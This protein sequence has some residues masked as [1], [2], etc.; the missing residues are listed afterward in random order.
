MTPS[1]DIFRL[2]RG[3]ARGRDADFLRFH[4]LYYDRLQRYLLAFS[5]DPALTNEAIQETYLRVAKHARVFREESPFWNWLCAI[6]RNA[7]RD[8]ARARR[9]YRDTLERLAHEDPLGAQPQ[10]LPPEADPRPQNLHEGLARL[11]D[12]DRQ[13]LM[14]KYFEKRTVKHIAQSLEISEK[15]VESRL[16]RARERLRT[17]LHA[18]NHA[19][20]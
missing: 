19:H 1:A 8:L 12:T 20:S 3:L 6:A 15:A 4:D 2:T 10:E 14:A 11:P 18:S 7:L 17:L 13:V 5:Q 9:R 16:S